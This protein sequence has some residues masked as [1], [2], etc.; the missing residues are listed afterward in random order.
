MP[1]IKAKNEV[2]ASSIVLSWKA[3]KQMRVAWVI[4]M[5]GA[6]EIKMYQ[7]ADV[8]LNPAKFVVKGEAYTLSSAHLAYSARHGMVEILPYPPK[9][10]DIKK[11]VD[12]LSK[13]ETL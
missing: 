5:N 7:L 1:A 11:I 8:W 4:E 2:N 9:F 6:T 3:P 12:S 13:Y 10:D